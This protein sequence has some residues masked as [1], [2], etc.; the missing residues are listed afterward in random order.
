MGHFGIGSNQGNATQKAKKPFSEY[1]E[2]L[3]LEAHLHYQ[4]DFLH[5]DLTKEEKQ[6]IKNNIRK[7]ERRILIRTSIISVVL[8][9]GVAY[10]AVHL[11]TKIVSR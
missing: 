9:I 7:Q 6:Q 8:F 4:M 10:A 1:K 11:I 2:R 3:D 5:V